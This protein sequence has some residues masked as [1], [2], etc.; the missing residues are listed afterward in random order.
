M[1]LA[2]QQDLK[3]EI[4]FCGIATDV[5]IAVVPDTERSS[6]TILKYSLHPVEL[7]VRIL[8]TV[9]KRNYLKTAFHNT[10]FLESYQ[11]LQNIT[12]CCCTL[13]LYVG[14]ITYS[15]MQH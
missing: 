9:N 7:K 15:V 5:V 6:L 4:S 14:D 1:W 10:L 11:L 13:S 3:A 2:S 8:F 12:F